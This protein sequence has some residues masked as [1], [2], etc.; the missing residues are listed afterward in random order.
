MAAGARPCSNSNLGYR[1]MEGV[2]PK[3][4]GPGKA[5]EQMRGRGRCA[6]LTRRVQQQAVSCTSPMNQCP[7]PD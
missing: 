5:Q 1:A 7:Q 6:A 2:N 3:R 4:C